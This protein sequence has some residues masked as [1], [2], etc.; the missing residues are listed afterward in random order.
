MKKPLLLFYTTLFFIFLSFVFKFENLGIWALLVFLSYVFYSAP[1]F[2]SL[3]LASFSLLLLGAW[4]KLGVE[5]AL[6]LFLLYLAMFFVQKKV[7]R[8]SLITKVFNS[9]L[10]ISIF[11]FILERDLFLNLKGYV[12]YFLLFGKLFE[13]FVWTFLIWYFAEELGDRI[14]EK[15]FSSHQEAQLNLFTGRQLKHLSNSSPFKFQK[16]VRRRF[17]LKDW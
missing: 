8:P 12:D 9:F 13:Y 7:L 6:F 15:F 4:S 3:F 14:E 17:G 1:F 5:L 16:R 10:W 2:V 11:Y